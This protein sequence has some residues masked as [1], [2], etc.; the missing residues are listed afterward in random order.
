[1]YHQAAPVFLF[2]GITDLWLAF[3]TDIRLC[4][5]GSVLTSGLAII[6]LRRMS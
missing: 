3:A 1:M 5:A 2:L 6:T 4:V